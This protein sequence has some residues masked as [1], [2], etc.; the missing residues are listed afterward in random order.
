MLLTRSPSAIAPTNELKRAF[1]PRSS[2]AYEV[3]KGGTRENI[4]SYSHSSRPASI[5]RANEILLTSSANTF[6][7]R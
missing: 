5:S 4:V 3:T 7:M 6:M 2:P 1:S